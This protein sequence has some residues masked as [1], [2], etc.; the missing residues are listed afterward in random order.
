VLFIVTGF[1]INECGCSRKT[2]DAEWMVEQTD[3]RIG[4]HRQAPSLGHVGKFD[5]SLN[6]TERYS[7]TRNRKTCA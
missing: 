4:G 5:I 7:N 3:G 6:K 2:Y 1:S